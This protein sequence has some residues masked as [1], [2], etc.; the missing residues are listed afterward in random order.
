ME[1]LRGSNE[2]MLLSARYIVIIQKLIVAICSIDFLFYFLHSRHG[3]LVLKKREGNQACFYRMEWL[4]RKLILVNHRVKP[5][6]TLFLMITRILLQNIPIEHFL[7]Q[8]RWMFIKNVTYITLSL[9][10]RISLKS[11]HESGIRDSLAKEGDL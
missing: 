8:H 1:F 4:M 6:I 11:R 7:I 2:I 10:C 5:L 9:T 3:L